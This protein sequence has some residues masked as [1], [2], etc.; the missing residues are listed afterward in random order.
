MELKEHQES[1]LRL[2]LNENTSNSSFDWMSGS[3][4]AIFDQHLDSI[5]SEVLRIYPVVQKTLGKEEFEKVLLGF[6]A[7]YRPTSADVR[8]ISEEFFKFFS[9]HPR[10]IEIPV[11]LGIAKL[12]L[13]REQVRLAPEMNSMGFELLIQKLADPKRATLSPQPHVR[14]ASFSH[15]VFTL[16]QWSKSCADSAGEDECARLPI[17]EYE[18][19]VLSFRKGSLIETRKITVSEARFVK[20]L[21]AGK[22]LEQIES[23]FGKINQ[24]FVEELIT[25]SLLVMDS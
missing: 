2:L 17:A 11:L 4:W 24:K 3:M 19:S 6:S 23:S 15:P 22:T 10:A 21:S 16:W 14:V 20:E 25:Q 8:E 9:R 5:R 13:Q 7:V 12:E 18:E 1:L